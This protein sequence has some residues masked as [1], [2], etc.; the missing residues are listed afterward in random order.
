M[1]K[2]FGK[3]LVCSALI[4]SAVAGGIA[5]YNKFKSS[6]DDFDDDSFDFDDFDD[7][8]DELEEED[9]KEDARGYVSIP[10]E[11]EV[12]D[13][14]EYKVNV[15]VTINTDEEFTEETDT[16]L[17]EEQADEAPAEENAAKEEKDEKSA[18]NQKSNHKK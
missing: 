15:N 18:K 6:D 13:E 3:F 5:L 7:D 16:E 12:P 1:S 11:N 9:S 4:G 2:K 17:V 8:F 14:D 10:I